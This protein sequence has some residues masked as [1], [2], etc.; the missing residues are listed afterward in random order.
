LGNAWGFDLFRQKKGSQLK[1][2]ET[3]LGR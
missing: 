3:H 2:E 1:T